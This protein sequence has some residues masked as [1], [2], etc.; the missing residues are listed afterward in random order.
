MSSSSSD[1]GFDDLRQNKLED[2]DSSD[3][4]DGKI[5]A[6]LSGKVRQESAQGGSFSPGRPLSMKLFASW[7]VEGNS[8][9][10]VPR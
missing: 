8:S 6:E 3:D 7:E 1:G 4:I 10:C 5:M 9:S 2:S